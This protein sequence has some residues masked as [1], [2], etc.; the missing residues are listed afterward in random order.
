[1]F[2]R[3]E[4]VRLAGKTVK[5]I[6]CEFEGKTGMNDDFTSDYNKW[7]SWISVSCPNCGHSMNVENYEG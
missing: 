5:C 2:S 3:E 1:M 6:M 7:N 4:R